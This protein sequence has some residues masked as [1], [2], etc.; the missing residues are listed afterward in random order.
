MAY[1]CQNKHRER[2]TDQERVLQPSRAGQLYPG[3]TDSW[4]GLTK[5]DYDFTCRLTLTLTTLK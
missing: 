2:R 4:Q 5:P 1:P 3:F